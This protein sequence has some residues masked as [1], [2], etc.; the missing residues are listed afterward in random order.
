MVLIC[1]NMFNIVQHTFH[2]SVHLFQLPGSDRPHT[3]PPHRCSTSRCGRPSR[4]VACGW[5]V[6]GLVEPRNCRTK[7]EYKQNILG[8]CIMILTIIAYNYCIIQTHR[9]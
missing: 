9:K 1:L 4:N 5:P 2:F 3:K 8:G 7:G 6:G